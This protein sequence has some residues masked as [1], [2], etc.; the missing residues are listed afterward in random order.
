MVMSSPSTGM[1]L[2]ARTMSLVDGVGRGL[3]LGTAP[4]AQQ[5]VC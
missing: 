2:L 1:L 3:G 5:E 4:S